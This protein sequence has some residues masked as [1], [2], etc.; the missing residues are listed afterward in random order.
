MTYLEWNNA[1]IKHFFNPEN[2]LKEVMLYFNEAIIDE[3]GINNF[4]KPEE[5]YV[6]D[7]Y[8]ALRAGVIGSP[9]E[10]YIGRMLS[11]EERYRKGV[12]RIDG[13]EFEYP[14]NLSYLIFSCQVNGCIIALA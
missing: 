2:E 9:N 6:E 8:K 1:I 11:L 5:G 7:F 4:E 12:Q 14:P 13:I 10:N 3:I